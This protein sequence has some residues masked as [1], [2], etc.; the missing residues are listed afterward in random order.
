MALVEL[1]RIRPQVALITL[2]RPERLNALSFPLVDELHAALDDVAADNS[3]R[4][5]I[6]T[7][8]GRAFCSGLDL[9]ETGG[10][11]VS[12]GLSGPAAGMRSQEHIA[13]LIPHLRAIPQPV[14]AAVNGVAVG[15]GF[16]LALGCDLRV[17]TQ[18]AHFNVQFIRVGVSGCDIG[19]S[20]TL[21]RLIGAARAFELILTARDVDSA[22]AERIGLVSRVAPD[23]EAVDAALEYAERILD[24]APFAVTMTKEVM[25]ANVAAP[26]LEAAIHLENRTQI[27]A[28][29]TGDIAE[30]VAAF[31]EKRKPDFTRTKPGER[32]PSLD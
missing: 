25:W 7:G 1:E 27:L 5:A 12:K 11:S 18:S 23:G 19:I 13:G 21:P 29:H 17:C 15:G 20:Y 6:V 22:E 28:S 9:K 2:N 8:A 16:A 10:A 31:A 32:L 4:V 24:L 14:I 26:S 30:A 3:L